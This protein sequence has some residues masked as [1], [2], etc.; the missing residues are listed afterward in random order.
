MIRHLPIALLLVLLPAPGW[1]AGPILVDTDGDGSA[2]AWRDNVI[3]FN[4]ESGTLGRLDNAE[5]VQMVRN[6]LEQWRDV[7]INGVSTVD[8]SIA[9]GAVLEDINTDNVGN[10]FAYCPSDEACLTEDPPFVSGGVGTGQSPIIFDSDGEITDLIQG[11][12]AKRSILGFA[13]PRVMETVGGKMV[14]TEGQAVLNGYYIDCP[15]GAAAND[16]CQGV[17]VSLGEFEGVIFH[18]L[19]HFI[20]LDHS[21]VNLSSA[22]KSLKGDDSEVG[23]IPTMFPIF[24][25][26]VAQGTPH[27]DDK[28]AVSKL[29]PSGEFAAQFCTLA[30]TVFQ[31]DGVTPMQGVNVVAT[32]PNNALEEA[33]SFV[34]GSYYTGSVGSCDNRAGGY[35]LAGLTPGVAYQ[36]SIEK[37]S[38]AFTGGSSIEPCDPP[39]S[40]FSA[41]VLGGDFSCAQGGEAIQN[42]T[43]HAT[44]IVTTKASTTTG[45]TGGGDSSSSAGG[46]S[47]IPE[48]SV[49]HL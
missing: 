29:Y 47:L 7:T 5:A 16:P 3:R 33:T 34:S 11:E 28:V 4:P 39:A 31:S 19:G 25:D 26:G 12:G 1:G 42:G 45:S 43:T 6:L 22:I 9:E 35:V 18:E 24:V 10:Y 14:I 38:Q 36:L 15:S 21:Q 48:N 46:C 37:I 44:D 13:G 8:F 41:E 30:G 49:Q 17:E 20:G 2:V 27:L 40:G 32:N 23:A